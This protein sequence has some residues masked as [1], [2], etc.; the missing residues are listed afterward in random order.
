MDKA[1]I[2]LKD[3][4]A[5]HE[6]T[7]PHDSWSRIIVFTG[8][9]ESQNIGLT[10]SQY[11]EL[12][13]KLTHIIHAAYPVNFIL[14]FESF[15]PHIIATHA[16]L[17][18]AL[19]STS[20]N[21]AKFIFCSSISVAASYS[22]PQCLVPSDF[23]PIRSKIPS[24]GY[25][26]SKLVCE[27][28]ISNAIATSQANAL[29]IRIGQ[30]IPSLHPSSS[31]L[32]NPS[33][34]IPLLIRSALATG[35]L[36]NRTGIGGDICSWLPIDT[37]A[38]AILQLGGIKD[39]DESSHPDLIEH[40][41]IYNLLHPHPLSWQQD[42]LPALRSAG[43]KFEVTDFDAWLMALR[44]SDPDAEKNPSIKLLAYWE[45]QANEIRTHEDGDGTESV[46]GGFDTSS[47]ERDSAVVRDAPNLVQEGDIGAFVKEWKRVWS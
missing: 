15:V 22:G 38:Q 16:L 45:E 37:A 32:W 5:A 1:I 40:R 46:G 13:S 10:T 35:R 28:I 20:S 33:E 24:T 11:Q 17:S 36:P 14:P 44:A 21:P 30:L 8:T 31:P 25:A 2:R 19:S 26:K 43:L 3:R 34:A 47:A 7:L 29:V 42:V 39:G 9:L 12:K 23:I 41:G 27:N 18:L 6:K 4:L